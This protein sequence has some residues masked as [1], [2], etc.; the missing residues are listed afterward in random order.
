M[1]VPAA[2]RGAL[3]GAVA[4]DADPGAALA[5]G[6]VLCADLAADPPRPILDA[7]GAPGLARLRELAAGAPRAQARDAGRCLAAA[8]LPAAAPRA[9]PRK[10]ARKP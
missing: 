1:P 6:A 2:L 5:A 3:A 9:A 10:P 7:L 4:G 8:G